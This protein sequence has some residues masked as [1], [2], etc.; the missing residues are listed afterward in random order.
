MSR[1]LNPLRFILP[2]VQQVWTGTSI[3]YAPGNSEKNIV[4]FD[5]KTLKK[6]QTQ[7]Q[8]QM[9]SASQPHPAGNHTPLPRKTLQ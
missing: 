9:L 5:F 7:T 8:T 1:L 6:T 3:A 4:D 2:A